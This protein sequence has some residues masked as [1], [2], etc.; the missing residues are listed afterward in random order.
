MLHSS[1]FTRFVAIFSLLMAA[2]FSAPSAAHACKCMFPEVAPARE[3]ATAV[4]EGRVTAIADEP[5]EG[6][7]GI[8]KKRVT[9]ALVRTWKGLENK[10]SVVVSTSASSASC[11]YMFEPNAS[12]LVYADG[13]EDALEVSGCS[14][15][16]PMSDAA[17]DLAVLGGGI[18]PVEVKNAPAPTTPPVPA[19]APKSGGCGS[20]SGSAS[21]GASLLFFPAT[22]L[23]L[24]ARRKRRA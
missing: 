3:G 9:L 7:V 8:G 14:R 4:F 20:V 12:Y 24:G 19:T 17:D 5:V 18:T 11:G 15:T 2:A 22:G 21:A 10:E 23:L 6:D 13:T 16:R 1:F